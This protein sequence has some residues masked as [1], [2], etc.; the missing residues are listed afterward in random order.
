M[1]VSGWTV[2]RSVCPSTST[3]V[4]C[5]AVPCLCVLKYY[6]SCFIPCRASDRL[7]CSYC[8][9]CR[10]RHKKSNGHYYD[11][12]PLLCILQPN[13]P[14]PGFLKATLLCSDQ[15]WL[16]L[17]AG[18]KRSRPSWDSFLHRKKR[19]AALK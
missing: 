19:R 14:R 16:L 13:I 8:F 9:C 5:V 1:V 10:T 3:P 2:C 17:H 15:I 11:G 4:S 18:I 7:A 6:M 12:G